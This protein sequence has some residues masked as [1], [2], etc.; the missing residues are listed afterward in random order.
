MR[1]FKILRF[2]VLT[3]PLALGFH[4]AGCGDDTQTSSTSSGNVSSS[5]SSSSSAGAGG[6]GGMAGSGGAG[7]SAMMFCTPG[8]SAPCYSGPDATKDIGLCK[9]G[10]WTCNAQGTAY[11][12]C[13]GEVLP[14]AEDCSQPADENCNGASADCSAGAWSKRFGDLDGQYGRSIAADSAGNIYITGT[15]YSSID[16]G[17]GA[18][19]AMGL[20]GFLAKFDPTGTLLWSKQFGGDAS[21]KPQ[22]LAVDSLGNVVVTGAFGGTT[23]FGTGPL[24]ATDL[25]IFVA[26]YDPAGNPLWSKQFGAADVQVSEVIALDAQ[27]NVILGSV[28]A[29]SVDFGGGAFTTTNFGFAVAKFD[30]DGNHIWSKA[31]DNDIGQPQLMVLAADATGN[32]AFGGYFHGSV[33]FGGGAL[34]ASASY[35]MFLAKFNAN[36]EHLWS[37]RYGGALGQTPTGM[38]FDAAG[39]LYAAGA[40]EGTI[41]FGGGILTSAGDDDIWMAKLDAGGN[42][43]WSKRFGDGQKQFV[44]GLAVSKSG[45]LAIP[46]TFAGTLDFGTTSI[47]SAGNLD[48]GHARFDSAGNNLW[49]RRAGDSLSQSADALAFDPTGHVICTGELVGSAD[50]GQGVLTSAGSAD[51]YLLKLLP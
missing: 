50:F 14:A 28:F 48:M 21:Q 35:D 31:F 13:M 40:F 39:N 33:D 5:S 26:K 12:P 43:I 2:L 6:S 46:I 32:I 36:G 7:G 41:D 24:V 30:F 17:A 25:D 51:L 29:N 15:F 44:T 22:S 20:D 18:Y 49:S 11:G 37:K 4:A 19:S 42:H 47:T 9:S 45:D 1:S 27:N 16:F 23:D 34:T 10:S 8:T 38:G 3:P